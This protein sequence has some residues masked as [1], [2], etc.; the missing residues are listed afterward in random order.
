MTRLWNKNFSILTIGSFVSALGSAAAGVVFGVK[1][2]EETHSTLYL[3]LFIIANIIPRLIANFAVGPYVDRHSRIKTIFTLDFFSAASFSLI[4]AVL[5]TGYFNIWVFTVV[6]AFFGIVDTLYQTAFMSLF[7]EVV[8]QGKHSQAYSISSL[9]WPLSGA[10]MAPIAI[11]FKG[12]LP[13]SGF[14]LIM[15]FNAVTFL[16]AALMET[17]IHVEET[18]NTSVVEAHRFR[19]DLKEGIAYYRKERG[20]LG[21]GLLF[22][23]FSFVYAV[24]D[25]LKMPFFFD[26]PTFTLNQFALL[27]SFSSVGRIVGGVF[28]YLY[29]FKK[30]HKFLIAISVYFTVEILDAI[31]LLTPFWF[32]ALS[33]FLVGVL[34]VTSFNIR[35]AATQT[36]IPSAKRGRVNAVQTLLWNMGAIAGTLIFSLLGEFTNI[37][38]QWLILAA[39]GVSISAIF[40]FPL[41]MRKDFRDIYN[42]DV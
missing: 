35:M 22:M 34:S 31:M 2:Y 42:V 30:E 26:S 14:A 12:A 36:Y 21:I 39:A 19:T 27:I 5:A 29:V 25:V 37:G 16:I 33:S 10:I 28:H 40:I 15:L 32:M 6:G 3:G 20:I 11:W 9:I 1:I 4:A 8:P 38:Y 7:P 17:K 23:A 18:L 41:R 13:E 24:S